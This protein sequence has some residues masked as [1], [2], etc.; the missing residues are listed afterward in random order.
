MAVT[1]E[2]TAF[3][4]SH[5]NTTLAERDALSF[6]TSD[7]EAFVS[8][9]RQKWKCEAAVLSTCNRTEL[10][11][12]GP[13]R[14]TLW[15]QVRRLLCEVKGLDEHRLP[16]PAVLQGPRAARH[17]FRVAASLE[18]LA[19]GE[20][21]ILAQ[22]KDVHEQILSLP[23]KSPTLERLFQY[24]IRVGKLVRT[25]TSLCEG[26]LS[27]GSAAVDLARKIFGDF[28]RTKI[29]LV[30]AGETSETA[31]LHFQSCGANDFVVLNRGEERGHALAARLGGR[32]M[33]LDTLLEASLEADI[34]LFAT[35]AQ[36][37]LLT[38]ADMKKVMKARSHRPIFL[39]DISNPRNIAPDVGQV[40]SVFLYN[41]DD[42]Q[43]VVSLN[44]KSRENEIPS[45]EAIVEHMLREWDAWLQ[46]Q[47]I[48]PTIASLARFFEEI[49]AQEL[50]RHNG[51][52]TEEERQ[53]LEN[54]SRGLIKKL[55]HHP[56]SYLKTS[57]ENQ[58]L[59]T[60]DLHLV[61]ALY[62]LDREEETADES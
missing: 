55:L 41:I 40:E 15:L 20:N 1:S 54:F 39:I 7:V 3:S 17:I 12:Y 6:S 26:S 19:L 27:I 23:G 53:M 37:H 58:T 52:I 45:A 24:A 31:A 34:A 33:A 47:Q 60:E 9:C 50:N 42:L 25:Q 51:R 28:S 44:L 8:V 14:D 59:R 57:V 13:G 16:I 2:L 4:F 56:I 5:R 48:T 43:Q 11:I 61:W 62:N 18:S 46:A 10:Y 49:R 38:R 32:F 29:L 30:G 21:Q 35:G 36:N 22:V